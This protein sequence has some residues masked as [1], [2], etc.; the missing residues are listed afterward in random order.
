MRKA[1]A[2]TK[3]GPKHPL[4]DASNCPDGSIFIR[5]YGEIRAYPIQSSGE[6]KPCAIIAGAASH[7]SDGLPYGNIAVSKNGFLHAL[8]FQSTDLN[9]LAIH[10]ADANGDDAPSRLVGASPDAVAVA[11]DS[12]INDYLVAD[13]N[14]LGDHCWF[15]VREGAS[16]PFRTNCD[17]NL[18]SIAALAVD[19]H[20]DL[21]AA[22]LD[23]T[24]GAVRLDVI[25]NPA[26]AAFVVDR[27]VTGSK[28]GLQPNGSL[29]IAVAPGSD[30]LYAFSGATSATTTITVFS[31]DARENAAPL[32]TI[33]SSKFPPSAFA[34]NVMA[35]DGKG[36]LYVASPDGSIL[37]YEAGASGQVNPVRTI[38][39]AG[40]ASN[41]T[42]AGIALRL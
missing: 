38:T 2:Q 23:A 29:A 17:T 26:T 40:A 4:E 1:T 14:Y 12:Q 19:S 34:A 30:Q 31:D 18:V 24:T 7:V 22:G 10:D 15:V 42:A 41:S 25:S 39:D 35:V 3:I 36:M 8:S 9:V 5:R 20:D 32:R 21:I 33:R 27:S 13:E 28:T 16:A 37:V 11:V 6:T